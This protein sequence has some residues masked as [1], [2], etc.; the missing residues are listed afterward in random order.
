MEWTTLLVT[1]DYSCILAQTALTWLC[2]TSQSRNAQLVTVIH[3]GSIWWLPRV[4]VQHNISTI[5]DINLQSDMAQLHRQPWSLEWP[6]C[7]LS[8]EPAAELRYQSETSLLSA[9]TST[10]QSQRSS[11]N[12][13]ARK[14]ITQC[15]AWFGDYNITSHAQSCTAANLTYSTV[16]SPEFC[17]GGEGARARGTRVPKFVVTKSSRSES[18]LALGL[19]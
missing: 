8:W 5:I 16:V 6:T 17:S 10:N 11:A 14:H 3:S 1:F 19:Q 2:T 9:R 4:F 13:T 18:H 7:V 12:L 15:Q